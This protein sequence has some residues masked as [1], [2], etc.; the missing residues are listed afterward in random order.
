MKKV[1]YVFSLLIISVAFNTLADEVC[2]SSEFKRLKELANKVEFNYDYKLIDSIEDENSY[3]DVDFTITATNLNEDLKVLIINDYYQG[4]YLEFKDNANHSSSLS[5]FFAGDRITVTIKGY[6]DNKCSGETILTK[7]IKL[8][9]LNVYY[10]KSFCKDNPNF[11]YCTEL[12]DQTIDNKTYESELEKYLNNTD[13]DVIEGAVK[14]TNSLVF[15][16]V[17]IFALSLIAA[18]VTIYV[19]NKKRRNDI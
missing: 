12:V 11:K 8:P 1:L 14:G 3:D 15:I 9:Y 17:G 13:D 18:G 2:P 19:I 4:D 6:T 16:I 10:N 5:G 7:T